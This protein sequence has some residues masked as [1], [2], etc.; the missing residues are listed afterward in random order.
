[1][2]KKAVFPGKYIQGVGALSELP[3]LM[4]LFGR[5]ALILA[6][7][8]GRGV[9]SRPHRG[10]LQLELPAVRPCLMYRDFLTAADQPAADNLCRR[11]AVRR[12]RYGRSVAAL[13]APP[14]LNYEQ[15]PLLLD[16]HRRRIRRWRKDVE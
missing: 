8:T 4:R 5:Q 6:A 10:R 1:M 2:F 11:G 16:S 12:D 13:S 3:A 14:T 15:S 7:Q 9:R